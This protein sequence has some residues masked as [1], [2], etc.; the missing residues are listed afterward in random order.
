M[1]VVII[2][3]NAGNILSVYYA[4]KRLGIT[5]QISDISE[6]ILKADKVIFPG[7]GEASS[8]MDYLK[9][10]NLDQV[11]CSLQKPVLGICLGMQLFC[12]YSEEKNTQCL[13]I[14]S[15]IQVRKF[16]S[17]SGNFK[18]PKIGWD[19][20]Y[21]C[22]SRLFHGINDFQYVYFVHGYFVEKNQF[23]SALSSFDSFDYCAAMEKDNFFGVQF[24]P[25]KSG[26][27]GE[28]ILQNFLSL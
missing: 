6:V 16:I 15:N 23:C 17:P 2:K 20:I 21:Q 28:K 9:R 14:F 22:N 26:R 10:K 27:T 3:Y 24:H 4:L 7:V 13:G 25:E 12:E 5:A 11:I 8:A 18:I 19:V 1:N